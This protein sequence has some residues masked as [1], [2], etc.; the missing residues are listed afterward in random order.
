MKICERPT[1]DVNTGRSTDR[2]IEERHAVL[3]RLR[4]CAPIY[5][6]MWVHAITFLIFG[7]HPLTI[8]NSTVLRNKYYTCK[9][10][11]FNQ[12]KEKKTHTHKFHRNIMNTNAHRV[13]KFF[14]LSEKFA[15]FSWYTREKW[16]E[17]DWEI[18]YETVI[19]AIATFMN[20]FS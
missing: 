9:C 4:A 1:V 17:V 15:L 12:Q 3:N 10:F 13:Y 19:Q 7:D 20:I 16:K 8:S 14:Y 2:Q 6:I 5:T 18:V 11:W